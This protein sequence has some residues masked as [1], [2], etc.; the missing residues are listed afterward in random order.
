MSN[1]D[2]YFDPPTAHQF[3]NKL[4]DRESN[5]YAGDDILAPYVAV[6]DRLAAAGFRVQTADFLPTEISEQKKIVI[7]FGAPDRL[8][9]HSVRRYRDLS[10]RPDVVLS[11]FFAME[12]PVVEP[13]MF[14][15]LPELQGYFR[16]LM[17]W[18]DADALLPFTGTRVKTG[19]FC[20]PQSF[21]RVHDT[22][23]ASRERKFLLMMNANKLPRVYKDELYT[24][25][26]RAVQFFHGFGEIDLY[27]RN[28]DKAPS[29]V[30]KTRTPYV[31]R[32]MESRLWT[33][34]QKVLP[35]PLYVAAA[36][37]TR[38]PARSKSQTVAQYRFSLC[39]ENSILKGWMT[40]KLFD[41]F[42]VGTI[43]VYWGAPD[44]LDYVPAESFIDMRQFR[45]FAELR[46]FLLA[47]T[48]ADEDQYRDAARAYLESEQFTP[49]RLRTFADT[50]AKIVSE[51]TGVP[52]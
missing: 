1:A 25:R 31:L 17:S 7:S 9:S 13:R 6:R 11:A 39:F 52:L 42:F 44:V 51:D 10:K 36:S 37:A 26:L 49:F 40:E 21:D 15:A 20:W 47:L 24:S 8:V 33:L 22:L 50:M 35:D 34:K 45:D 14:A 43:P 46:R 12:C 2:I 3:G 29:R 23:W 19:H 16:R 48:P 27:G 28:W 4:F 38:G 41:C 32:R 5:P 18:S 30:G